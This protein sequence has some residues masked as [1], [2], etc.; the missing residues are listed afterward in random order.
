MVI[1]LKD[2]KGITI[3]NAFQEILDGS[4]CKSNK[5]K[6]DKGSE[7]YNQSMKSWIEK[8]NIKMYPTHM[9]Y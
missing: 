6:A 2:K 9:I 7:F 4:N 3:N 1:R 8:N 5:T